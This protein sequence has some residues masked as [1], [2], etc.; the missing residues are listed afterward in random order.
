MDILI[1]IESVVM[2]QSRI[3]VLFSLMR[4]IKV[5]EHNIN[6]TLYYTTLP[7][8]GLRHKCLPSSPQGS[9]EK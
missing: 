8:M 4:L 1:I 5:T 3:S 9:G 6:M 7:D 2:R